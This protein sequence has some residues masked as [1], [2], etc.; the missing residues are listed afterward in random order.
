MRLKNFEEWFAIRP[1]HSDDGEHL[2]G[3]LFFDL[4]EGIHVDT[5]RF[6]QAEKCEDRPLVSGQTMTGWLDYQRPATI[7]Q[8]WLQK[9]GGFTFSMDTPALRESQRFIGSSILKNVFLEDLN[10]AIFTGIIVEHPAFHAWVNPHLVDSDWSV[11]EDIGLPCLSVDVQPPTERLFTLNDGTKARVSSATRVPRGQAT[12]LEEYSVLT[13]R[14][15]E[16][17]TYDRIVRL[18]WSISAL[19]E[20]LIS[21]RVQ[22]PIYQLSTTHKRVWNNEEREVI[23]ELWY[24]PISR[25]KRHESTPNVHDR[26][27]FEKRSPVPLEALL[28]HA[29]GGSDELVYLADLVQSAEDHDLPLTQGFGELLGCLEAFDDRTFGSGAD[30]NFKDKMRNLAELVE[31]YGSDENKKLFARIKGNASNKFS[32]LRR[33]ERLHQI[34]QKDEFRGDPKLSRIRDLRNIIPHGRGLE[35]SGDIAQEMITYL[36]YLTALGRY[37]VLKT[38][39]FTGT[40][41]AAAFSWQPHRYGMFVPERMAPKRSFPEGVEAQTEQDPPTA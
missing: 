20:F 3:R 32:L 7:I 31:K 11:P 37:H 34:W 33:L 16:P 29:V 8:P 30:E 25:K 24:R 4:D 1:G 12:T 9:T 14:F 5:I 17:V 21:A 38:L 39:G 23:A 2:P 36:H 35:I 40:E 27:T 19:F 13:L 41:V 10:S 28:N 22:A 15:P 26:L 18:T 6:S